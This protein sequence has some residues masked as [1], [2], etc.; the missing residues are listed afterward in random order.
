MKPQTKKN[1]LCHGQKNTGFESKLA[2]FP[3]ILHEPPFQGLVLLPGLDGR[4]RDGPPERV[5]ELHGPEPVE[6]EV[7]VEVALAPDVVEGDGALAR[8]R[9]ERGADVVLQKDW[10][11]M[12][13]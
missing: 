5:A 9:L 4:E 8:L 2:L 11:E 6:L 1:L 13:C 7:P 12:F 10:N 3:T